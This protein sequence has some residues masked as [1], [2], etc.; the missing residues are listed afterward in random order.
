MSDSL[1]PYRLYVACQVHGISQARILEQVA[2]SFSRGSS[3][4]RD[5]TCVSC[6]AGRIL[7]PW[8]AW[9]REEQK[10][11]MRLSCDLWVQRAGIQRAIYL[12]CC[13][14]NIYVA[15]TLF[16][17]LGYRQ[18]FN[19]VITSSNTLFSTGRL[20]WHSH[21][22]A[23]DQRSYHSVNRS[24]CV[25]LG[26]SVSLRVSPCLFMS[27]Q[28]SLSP[29]LC[30]SPSVEYRSTRFIMPHFFSEHL[31]L[32]LQQV[33]CGIG[34]PLE[35]HRPPGDPTGGCRAHHP[36]PLFVQTPVRP[37]QRLRQYL[38]LPGRGDQMNRSSTIWW[39]FICNSPFFDVKLSL[40]YI[41]HLLFAFIEIKLE[42][43]KFYW[44]KFSFL[45]LYYVL[46]HIFSKISSHA[47]GNNKTPAKIIF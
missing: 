33:G 1:W 14:W 40:R 4:P 10:T 16:V 21:R 12:F 7:Y 27:L 42:K 5:W 31:P 39:S 11:L 28:V 18:L 15:C 9:E 13:C 6:T 35:L 38:R 44:K 3:W 19:V 46:Y 29:S 22:M 20:T 47:K 36:H 32:K 23:Q 2:I 17:Q 37:S 41:R 30:P 8:A 34:W 45:L 25:S 43:I 24:L 26:L